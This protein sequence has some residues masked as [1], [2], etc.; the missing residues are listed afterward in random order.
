M[1]LCKDVWFSEIKHQQIWNKIWIHRLI[2]NTER[3]IADRYIFMAR[4]RSPP[5]PL[6]PSQHTLEDSL[7]LDDSSWSCVKDSCTNEYSGDLPFSQQSIFSNLHVEHARHAMSGVH[8]QPFSAW[9]NLLTWK[10][11][12]KWEYYAHTHARTCTHTIHT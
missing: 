7:M 8:I 2:L 11:N 6:S 4:L 9:L 12:W 1:A 3:A 5:A 10:H